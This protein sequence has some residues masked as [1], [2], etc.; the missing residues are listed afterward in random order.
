MSIS[1][2][3]VSG[4]SPGGFLGGFL[5]AIWRRTGFALALLIV[6]LVVNVWLNP[7]RFSPLAWGTLIGLA[8]P[9][10]GAALASTPAI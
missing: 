9:L 6:L 2:G 3:A 10:I 1:S 4:G 7:A 8:A 5:G